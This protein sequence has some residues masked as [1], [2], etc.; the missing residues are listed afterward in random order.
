MPIHDK[1]VIRIVAERCLEIDGVDS[2]NHS[3]IIKEIEI[4][5]VEEVMK[6]IRLILE[7]AKEHPFRFL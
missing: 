1:L 7:E 4:D 5:S 3:L 2:M 6:K